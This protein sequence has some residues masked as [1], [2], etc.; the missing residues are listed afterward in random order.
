MIR[1]LSRVA[2]ALDYALGRLGRVRRVLV[3]LRTPVSKAILN[4]IYAPLLAMPDVEVSFTSEYPDRIRPLV[5]DG[6]FLT[7]A[8]VEWRRFD[9]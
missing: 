9:V 6:R 5:P 3:E 1:R 2:H 7:H 8:Q 4:P